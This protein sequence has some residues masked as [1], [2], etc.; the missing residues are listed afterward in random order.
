MIYFISFEARFVV[1]VITHMRHF[2][3]IQQ[4]YKKNNTTFR[5]LMVLE[6]GLPTF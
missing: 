6:Q 5:N 4:I 2:I 1:E 3:T